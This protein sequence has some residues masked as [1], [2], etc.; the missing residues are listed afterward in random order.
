MKSP[1]II[2]N[3]KNKKKVVSILCETPLTAE[4]GTEIKLDSY[5]KF[6]LI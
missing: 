2:L 5:I 1:L 3:D 4:D 6:I